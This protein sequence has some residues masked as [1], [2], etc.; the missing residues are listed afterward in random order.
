MRLSFF[1]IG[2]V[3]LWAIF[4]VGDQTLDLLG[5]IHCGTT[6][7]KT[8]ELNI[9]PGFIQPKILVHVISTEDD[10]ESPVAVTLH[11]YIALP[12]RWI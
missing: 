9:Q 4:S 5:T 6:F 2:A 12:L 7:I 10:R 8:D 3:L 1:V 11:F